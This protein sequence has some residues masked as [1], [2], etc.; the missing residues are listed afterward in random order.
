[1]GNGAFRMMVLLP[2]DGTDIDAFASSITRTDWNQWASSFQTKKIILELPRFTLAYERTLNDDLAA[3][4]MAIA[5]DPVRADFS[6]IA[7][8]APTSRLYISLVKHK[9]WVNVDEVGTEA[10]AATAVGISV[11]SVPLIPTMRVD[12]PFVFAIRERLS[13][14]VL[15]VGKVAGL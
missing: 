15:F 3:M 14:T 13:G 5:F 6:R 1:Y 11:T 8:I 9:S 2:K 7:P 4:G 12:R 10:A